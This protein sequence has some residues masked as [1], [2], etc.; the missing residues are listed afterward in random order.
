MSDWDTLAFDVDDDGV[1]T[2]TVD[3]PEKLNSLTVET[4]EALEEALAA[5]RDAEARCLVLAG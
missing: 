2:I 1:A 4:L 5:A 3:R